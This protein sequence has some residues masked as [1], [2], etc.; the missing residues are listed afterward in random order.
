ME[1]RVALTL[2]VFLVLITKI[3][4]QGAQLQEVSAA[5]W[6][7]GTETIPEQT[8]PVRLSGEH[9]QYSIDVLSNL[10]KRYRLNIVHNPVSRIKVDHWKIELREVLTNE[11]GKEVLGD[12]LIFV[13]PP[14][15]GPGYVLREELIGY[16]IPST[17]TSVIRAGGVRLIEGAPFYPIEATRRIRIERFCLVAKV[18]DLLM[19]SSDKNK[20]VFLNLT[21]NFK[22]ACN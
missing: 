5:S 22:K 19:S 10:G 20:V 17:N 11:Q 8:V 12:D 2:G 4:A 14:G 13:E 21:I 7:K 3:F 16:L 6:K 9:P 18:S 15:M 1:M